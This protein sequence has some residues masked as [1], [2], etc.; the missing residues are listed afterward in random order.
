[1]QSINRSKSWFFEN[2]NMINRV[3]A[4]LTE[5]VGGSKLTE[6][7]TNTEITIQSAPKKFRTL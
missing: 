2:I 3:L 6:S 4:Q 5:R 1:M 7:E